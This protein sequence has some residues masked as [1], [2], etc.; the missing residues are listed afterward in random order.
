MGDGG[1]RS[2][3]GPVAGLSIDASS[4]RRCSELALCSASSNLH[5]RMRQSCEVFRV[6]RVWCCGLLTTG[7]YG[8][9]Q[10]RPCVCDVKLLHRSLIV[11]QLSDALQ[12]T[13][14]C[15]I[16]CPLL[17]E[18]RVKLPDRAHLADRLRSFMSASS[19][20]YFCSTSFRVS[21]RV[22]RRTM[23]LFTRRTCTWRSQSQRHLR[24][25][26]PVAHTL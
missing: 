22:L 21:T 24:R 26:S 25:W 16:Q 11:L 13:C 8:N 18:C 17:T 1:S 5:Q 3:P 19:S 9:E 7:N 10:P 14:T 20:R 15:A 4:D 2:S 6:C 23:R 12:L